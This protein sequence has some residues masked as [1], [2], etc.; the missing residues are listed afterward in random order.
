VK[1]QSKYKK[2]ANDEENKQKA[3]IAGE[4]DIDERSTK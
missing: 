3:G 1:V 2:E 4:P